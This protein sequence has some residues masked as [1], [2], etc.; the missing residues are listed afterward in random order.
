MLND[1]FAAFREVSGPSTIDI[2][3]EGEMVLMISPAMFSCYRSNGQL[4]VDAGYR[5]MAR[6]QKCSTQIRQ[7][8]GRFRCSLDPSHFSVEVRSSAYSPAVHLLSALPSMC[9][10]A[11]ERTDW[12]WNLAG[13]TT[14]MCLLLRSTLRT[15]IVIKLCFEHHL[16]Y[17]TFDPRTVVLDVCSLTCS[18]HAHIRF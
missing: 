15:C 1:F 13:G 7:P 5:A 12:V 2:S 16:Q 3:V 18:L 11:M 8:Q 10:T 17:D 14:V 6:E 9:H 4:V